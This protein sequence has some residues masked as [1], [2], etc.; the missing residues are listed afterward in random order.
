[1][2][3]CAIEHLY[4]LKSYFR[5]KILIIALL[6]IGALNHPILNYGKIDG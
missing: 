4:Y 1:M 5:W 3:L 2:P 6:N